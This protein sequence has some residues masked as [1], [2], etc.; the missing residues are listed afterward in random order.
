MDGARE[1]SESSDGSEFGPMDD[2]FR[3]K[4][5]DRSKQARKKRGGEGAQNIRNHYYHILRDVN[6]TELT[7]A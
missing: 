1:Q 6:V 5:K 7:E 4:L 2:F 3:D